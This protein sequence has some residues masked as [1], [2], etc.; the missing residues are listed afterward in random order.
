[1]KKN[2]E[3]KRKQKN[4]KDSEKFIFRINFRIID[5]IYVNKK[6]YIY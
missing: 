1:M 2:Y 6:N 3:K 5:H 4:L